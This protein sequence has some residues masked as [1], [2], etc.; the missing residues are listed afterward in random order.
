MIIADE[1]RALGY[2]VTVGGSSSESGSADALVTYVD[3]WNWDMNMYMLSLSIQIREPQSES[4]MATAQTTRSSLVR[5]SPN[6]MASETLGVLL[7]K[8]SAQ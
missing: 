6:E 4:V 5:K 3:R 2:R 1:L 8:P 7:G